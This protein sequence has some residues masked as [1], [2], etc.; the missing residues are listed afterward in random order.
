VAPGG[1]KITADVNGAVTLA[2]DIAADASAIAL[3]G[4]GQTGVAKVITDL[5]ALQSQLTQIE[6]DLSGVGI[7]LSSN[8]KTYASDGISIALI[9]AE[10]W[11]AVLQAK[12]PAAAASAARDG[13]PIELAAIRTSD[14]CASFDPGNFQP[15]MQQ[16]AATRV[17]GDESVQLENLAFRPARIRMNCTGDLRDAI[18]LTINAHGEA[19]PT[20]AN[21]AAAGKPA[22]AAQFKRQWNAIC[23]KWGHPEKQMKITAAETAAHI[24]TLGQR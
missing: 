1:T 22:T 7:N 13:H 17:S 12:E 20:P 19:V 15:S 4:A 18:D 16:I 10:G 24:F 3:A 8:D 11:E 2:D 23:K 5:T 9:A 6:T 14:G 21:L